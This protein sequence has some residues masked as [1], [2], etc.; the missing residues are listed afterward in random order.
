MASNKTIDFAVNISQRAFAFAQFYQLPTDAIY[1]Q[2]VCSNG[3]PKC[4]NRSFWNYF[5]FAFY[6]EYFSAQIGKIKATVLCSFKKINSGPVTF[7][8]AVEP[9]KP[10]PPYHKP[11]FITYK[12]R[13]VY[14]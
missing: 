13:Y 11:Q 9:Y 12:K 7:Y 4:P 2:P 8:Y 3:F 10:M 1:L 5:I 14:G 6:T